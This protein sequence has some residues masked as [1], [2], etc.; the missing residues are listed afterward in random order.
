MSSHFSKKIAAQELY[1]ER[2]WSAEDIIELLNIEEEKLEEWIHRERWGKKKAVAKTSAKNILDLQ[3]KAF[4]KFL[5]EHENSKDW[6]TLLT[7]IKQ[8]TESIER[9]KEGGTTPASAQEVMVHFAKY[10]SKEIGKDQKI[11]YQTLLDFQNSF[12]E[13]HYGI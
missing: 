12:L 8:F 3:Q 11:G 4:E 2:N 9:A 10:M 6:Q 1:T 13:L 7:G 5:L